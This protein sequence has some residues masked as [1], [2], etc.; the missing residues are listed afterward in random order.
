ME[1]PRPERVTLPRNI[2]DFLLEL[3][4]ALHRHS[5]YPA[6][7]PSLEPAVEAVTRRV[8]AILHDRSSIAVGVTRRQLL[9]DDVATDP[10]QPVLRRLAEG[11]HRHR[12]GALSVTCGV[13]APEFGDALRQLSADA[14]R[15]GPIDL[16]PQTQA[17]WPHLTLHPLDFDGL[18]LRDDGSS[19]DNQSRDGSGRDLWSALA[20]AAVQFERIGDEGREPLDPAVVARAINEQPFDEGFDREIVRFLIEIAHELTTGSPE[21]VQELQQ[22]VRSLISCLESDTL[23]RLL[24]SATPAEGRGQFMRDVARGMAVDAVLDIVQ[25]ASDEDRKSTRLN[26]SHLGISYAVFC[27]KKKSTRQN[28]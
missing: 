23:R 9:V 19:M 14:E 3:S 20:R 11:L 6:G 26:S 1:A 27:L 8:Q 2:S 17:R 13:Q 5:M 28:V 12:I 15:D 16:G 22:R 21:R 25:A 24:H 18:A 4:I 7:H 10:D